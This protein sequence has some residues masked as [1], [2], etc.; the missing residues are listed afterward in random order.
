MVHARNYD[1]SYKTGRQDSG[2][3]GDI[4]TYLFSFNPFWFVLIIQCFILIVS[5]NRDNLFCSENRSEAR[6]FD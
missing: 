6:A 5:V 3:F 4:I 2:L 1:F